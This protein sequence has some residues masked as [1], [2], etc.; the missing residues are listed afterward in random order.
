MIFLFLGSIIPIFNDENL[1]T[2][3]TSWICG[4]IAYNSFNA[5]SQIIFWVIAIFTI[6]IIVQ[7]FNNH[8]KHTEMDSVGSYFKSYLSWYKE[9][10]ESL[11]YYCF[12]YYTTNQIYIIFTLYNNFSALLDNNTLTLTVYLNIIGTTL[13]NICVIIMLVSLTDSLDSAYQTILKLKEILQD[14]FLGSVF[15][16]MKLNT[17]FKI[18]GFASSFTFILNTLCPVSKDGRERHELAYL[19]Q[20]AETLGPMSACGYFRVERST[21][22]S[23]LSVRWEGHMVSC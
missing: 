2:K 16:R 5:L 3:T 18:L 11:K 21:L 4:Y 12:M 20:K 15:K 19:L 8:C 10:E 7:D 17:H 14:R 6:Q 1:S 22:T 23:M 13:I 9:I